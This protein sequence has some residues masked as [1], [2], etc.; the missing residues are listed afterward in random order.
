[1]YS[2]PSFT[3]PWREKQTHRSIYN[4]N[5][6]NGLTGVSIHSIAHLLSSLASQEV[7][8]FFIL[9]FHRG[10]RWQRD[11]SFDSMVKLLINFLNSSFTW[12][13]YTWIAYHSLLWF[14]SVLSY[15]W[16]RYLQ[17][18]SVCYRYIIANHS[19]SPH[20]VPNYQYKQGDTLPSSGSISFLSLL[21]NFPSFF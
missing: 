5:F 16:N 3:L 13:D 2:H 10:Y 1:M 19:I 20:F 21:Y 12:Q 4:L 8:F 17:V 9:L 18:S 7:L 11:P 15:A 14:F 6:G